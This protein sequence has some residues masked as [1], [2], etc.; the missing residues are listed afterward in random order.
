MFGSYLISLT[1]IGSGYFKD[2]KEL[3]IMKGL[4]KNWQ[5]PIWFFKFL[6]TMVTYLHLFFDFLRTMDMSFKNHLENWWNFGAILNAHWTLLFTSVVGFLILKETFGLILNFFSSFFSMEPSI[7]SR[8][9]IWFNI[10]G[11]LIL[12]MHS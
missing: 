5:V 1:T 12:I 8:N 7:W 6:K 2:L 9:Q 11:I 3:A 10:G 4:I